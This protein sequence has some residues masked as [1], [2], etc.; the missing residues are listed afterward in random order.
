MEACPKNSTNLTGVYKMACNRCVRVDRS[1]L[2]FRLWG[3]TEGWGVLLSTASLL[4]S[5]MPCNVSRFLGINFMNA[6]DV[7]QLTRAT[8]QSDKQII[9]QHVCTDES[10]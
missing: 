6:Y 7:Y 5:V 3:G 10:R 1:A 4:L 9:V 2:A 8:T